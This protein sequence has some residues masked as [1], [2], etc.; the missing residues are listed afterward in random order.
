MAQRLS[1]KF[2]ASASIMQGQV[3]PNE[4]LTT[5]SMSAKRTNAT[6]KAEAEDFLVHVS[7]PP[8]KP[9]LSWELQPNDLGI[10]M[11]L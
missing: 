8:L 5:V 9:Q 7:P 10:C 1:G 3:L 11:A 4:T 6:P 2:W